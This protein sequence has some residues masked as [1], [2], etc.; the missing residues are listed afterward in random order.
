LFVFSLKKFLFLGV[1]TKGLYK[2]GGVTHLFQFLTCILESFFYEFVGVTLLN[3]FLMV[4]RNRV[5]SY[6]WNTSYGLRRRG[7]SA[8]VDGWAWPRN[9]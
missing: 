1:I 9:I 7:N 4:W 8:F 2:F 3:H 5:A 6:F